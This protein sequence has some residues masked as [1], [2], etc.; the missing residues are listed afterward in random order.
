MR[1]NPQASGT[2]AF[3][4]ST[5]ISVALLLPTLTK[6]FHIDDPVVLLVSERILD[7]PLDPM[8]GQ[9]DWLGKLLPLWQVTT[10]PPLLSYYLAAPLRWFGYSEAALHLALLPFLLLLVYSTWWLARR[11]CRQPWLPT[12]FV[13]ASPAVVVSI[14]LMRDV[15][16]AALTAAAAALAVRGTDR[17]NVGSVLG[18][19][20]LLGA[21]ILTKYSAAALLPVLMLYPLGKRR[22]TLSA[23][24]AASL[25]PLLGWSLWTHHL[26]GTAHPLFLLAGE[27]SGGSFG[28]PDKFFGALAILGSSLLLAPA[29]LL[30]SWNRR[31]VAGAALSLALA[32]ALSAT[33]YH[34]T[35][36]LQFGC[37]VFGGGLLLILAVAS[38]PGSWR[39][40]DGFFL[41]VWLLG[42]LLFSVFFV[43]FQAVRHLIPALIPLTLLVFRSFDSIGAHWGRGLLWGLLSLQAGLSMAVAYAD[44]QYADCYRSGASRLQARARQSQTPVWFVGHWG[45]KLYAQRAGFRQLHANGPAPRQGD[46]LVWP[47]RVHIGNAFSGHPGLREHWELVESFPCQSALPVRTMNFQGAAFYAVI[48]G[49]SPFAFQDLP[50]ETFRVYR[51]GGEDER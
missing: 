38:P 31:R 44:Y 26:Y 41:L 45:W 30:A 25:L 2:L 51:V 42:P 4:L 17:E 23:A 21:A 14:N 37:W 8:G 43:P 33:Y 6:P 11:F 5:L 1:P 10:N 20:G 18:G 3:T 49:N 39:D 7:D 12:L 24:L 50:L 28:A 29:L 22:W 47:Q 35:V 46:W 40:P 16:A 19:A 32:A 36:S 13:L 9:L 34:A 27:H 48:R 15:P